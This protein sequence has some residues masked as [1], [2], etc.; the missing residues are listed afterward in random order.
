[1]KNRSEIIHANPIGKGLDGFRDKH[2]LD[3]T[4]VSIVADNERTVS[5]VGFFESQLTRVGKKKAIFD[6]LLAL[7]TLPASQLL[8]P[9]RSNGIFHYDLIRLL[10][11]VRSN[12]Y[13]L[14]RIKPLLDVVL[15]GE[16]D[17]TIWDTVYESMPPFRTLSLPPTPWSQN[18]SN[19][20]N[21]TE[22]CK[23]VGISYETQCIL[24]HVQST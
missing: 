20:S 6:L 14:E 15:N 13:D 17:E 16:S 19:L 7:Q 23:Y 4:E 3:L 11:A 1:M 8:P 24:F 21:S 12:C 10:S 9:K 5:L 18:T 22:Q 2:S